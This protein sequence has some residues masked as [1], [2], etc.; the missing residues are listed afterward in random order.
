[1]SLLEDIH[2]DLEKGAARLVAEYREQLCRDAFALCGDAVEAEDLAFRT[3]D[4]AIRKIDTFRSECSFY[5]WMKSILENLYRSSRRTKAANGTVLGELD[6]DTPESA[7]NL[8]AEERILAASDAALVR[9]AID[10]LP[11]DLKETI[12]LHYFMDQPVAKIAKLLTVPEG[13]VKFRL[14]YARRTLAGLLAKHLKRPAVRIA[15][16][17]LG[18]SAFA[19][20]VCLNVRPSAPAASP[21]S[22]PVQGGDIFDVNKGGKNMIMARKVASLVGA[23][24]LTVTSAPGAKLM[25]ESTFIFLKPEMSSFWNTATNNTMTVPV[26]F[27]PGAH[28]A[29]LTVT[30]DNY[31]A[32][33]ANITGSDYTFNLPVPDKPQTENVYDLTLSFDDG[34]SRRAKLGL[35]QGLDTGARGGTR[36][37]A[38]ADAN[39]WNRM[40]TRAVLPIPYGTTSFSVSVNGR[41][42]VNDTGLNGAQGWYALGGIKRRD[43]VTLSLLADGVSHMTTLLG[44]GDGYFVINIQ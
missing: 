28:S 40:G 7:D 35:I 10:V 2:D 43:Q 13:T 38:P 5:S 39:V 19:A 42:T 8:N 20:T 34:T 25:S 41:Q 37:L 4:R 21:V 22:A 44:R 14:H 24:I 31:S 16:L 33:Y 23:S 6:E 30:G 15:L 18:L 3:F 32:R 11:P 26:D 12:L 17:A 27:P 1:M 29:T 36:C 9:Q